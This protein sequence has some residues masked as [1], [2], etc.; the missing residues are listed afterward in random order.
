[1]PDSF[2]NPRLSVVIPVYNEKD[3][4]LKEFIKKAP[5][6]WEILIVDDGSKEV[7]RYASVRH[8]ENLGYGMAI[9]SGVRLARADYIATMDGDGQHSL[10]DLSRLF[11]FI[12]YMGIDMA[13]GDRRLI[14]R[15]PLR[16]LGRKMLTWTA[17]LFANRYI[18][19]LNSGMRIF[20]KKM[21]LGYEP[22]LCD[23]FS[24]TTSLTLASL[25][26]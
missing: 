11:D 1:M 15:T 12:R 8:Q 23:G 24:Y 5:K 6:E 21:A 16:W 3:A 22:I 19:D 17:S 25:A 9:K 13:I 26:D 4:C 18:N 7:H 2:K 10:C 20:K 14:E